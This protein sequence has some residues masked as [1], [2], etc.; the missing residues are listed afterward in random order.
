M[1]IHLALYMMFLL[2][3]P[4]Y[5]VASWYGKRFK[6]RIMANGKPFNPAKY[7][8]ASRTLPF[9]TLVKVT[10][11]RNH[12]TVVVQ[13]TDRGPWIPGRVLDL[14]HGAATHIGCTGLCRVKYQIIRRKQYGK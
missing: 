7:T 3:K 5:G 1:T 9:G 2:G 8:A 11:L 4:R 6:G 12:K 10:N 13:I 14:S